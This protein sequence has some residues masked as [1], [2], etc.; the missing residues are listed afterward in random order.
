LY[1]A[2]QSKIWSTLGKVDEI[3]NIIIDEFVQYAVDH[4]ISSPQSEIVANTIV[5]LSSV[6]IRGK[7]IAKLRKVCNFIILI[8]LVVYYILVLIN[9]VSFR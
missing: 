2:V 1:T 4:G 3:T 7:I 5:T 9:F 6:N 8:I